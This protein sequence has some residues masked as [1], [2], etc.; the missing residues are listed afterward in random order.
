MEPLSLTV[1]GCDGSYPGPG[2][3]GSGYLL[4]C[5]GT[6]VWLDAGPGTM[7]NLQRHIQLEDVD[8]VVVSHE[9]VDHWSDLEHMAV[10][11]HYIVERPVIPLYCEKD[12]T[13]MMRVGPAKQAFGWHPIGPESEVAIG[14]MTF[15]FSRT[16]HSVDTLA[17]RVEGAGRS[18]G[19][20]ADS[21]PG[22]GFGALGPGLDLALCEATFLAE[23]EGSLPHMSARQAGRAARDAGVGRL[24][25]THLLA[26][27]DRQ[28]SFAEASAAFGRPVEM[29][30]VGKRFEP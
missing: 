6:R 25:L 13:S 22:W 2:G 3:A 18:L 17:V 19:Y 15:T 8:A 14:P 5:G 16:D 9:H 27:V 12:L 11:C 20:S 10:A 28:A 21:G 1:L 30:E 29:A 23:R 26:R 4:R 7:A 24:V